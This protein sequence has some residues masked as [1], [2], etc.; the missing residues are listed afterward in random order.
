MIN[1]CIEN[2]LVI[3][4]HLKY[5]NKCLRGN[6]SYKQ[7]DIWKSE[8]DLYII[9]KDLLPLLEKVEVKQDIG[10]SD[11]A[12]I[13]ISMNVTTANVLG[14]ILIER[15][16]C[17]GQS[18]ISKVCKKYVTSRTQSF[19]DTNMDI[20]R[21]YMSHQE[22]PMLGQNGIE[23]ILNTSFKIINE[24]AK[25]SK[26]YTNEVSERSYSPRWKLL[27]EKNDPAVIWRAINWKGDIVE[28]DVVKP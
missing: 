21:N 8:I 2:S 24:G 26:V 13:C 6:L 16:Q 19:K 7:K 18:Y 11:H 12:P 5:K 1:T 4:N 15:A 22:P 10:R 9:H 3:A 14:P 20:F 23:E 28:S 17:L 25:N 27:M